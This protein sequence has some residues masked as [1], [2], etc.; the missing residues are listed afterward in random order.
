MNLLGIIAM[1]LPALMQG[2]EALFSDRPKTGQEKK[3]A[4]TMAAKAAVDALHQNSRGGQKATWDKLAPAVDSMIDSTAS[5]LFP[6]K[7]EPAEE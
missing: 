2:A 7:P 1:L 4:V 5:L 3:S 6:N